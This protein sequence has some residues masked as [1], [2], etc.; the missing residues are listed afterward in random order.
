MNLL[1]WITV[2]NKLTEVHKRKKR[3]DFFSKRGQLRVLN[4]YMKQAAYDMDA[5][6]IEELMEEKYRVIND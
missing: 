2:I 6:L 1:R 3:I 5:A 4:R